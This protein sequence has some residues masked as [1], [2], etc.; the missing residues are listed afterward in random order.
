M[1]DIFRE[2]VRHSFFGWLQKPLLNLRGERVIGRDGDEAICGLEVLAGSTT[3]DL[4]PE[5]SWSRC[6]VCGCDRRI[7]CSRCASGRCTRCA[8][9]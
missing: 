8:G 4:R 9:K 5:S 6:T 7:L 3:R 1:V 2:I